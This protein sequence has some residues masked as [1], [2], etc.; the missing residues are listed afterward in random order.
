MFAPLQNIVL[1]LLSTFEAVM[2]PDPNNNYIVLD[3]YGRE[4]TMGW[5]LRN[6]KVL[7][8]VVNHLQ[9]Y[10]GAYRNNFI[11]YE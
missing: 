2:P 6:R 8:V 4:E 1:L 10:V 5:L 11:K 7:F 9:F 3:I